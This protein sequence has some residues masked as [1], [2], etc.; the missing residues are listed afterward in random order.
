MSTTTMETFKG[1]DDRDFEVF[2]ISGLESRMDALIERVRPKFH[3]LGE[4]ISQFLGG[5]C[6]EE[7]FTHVAKHA[8]RTVN[9]PNDSWVAFA[10]NKRGYKAHPH[11]QIGLWSTHVFVQFAIIYECPNKN[12]FAE[13]ALGELDSI[14]SAVPDHYVWSKD[15][16][17]P[18]GLTHSDLSEEDL[19]DLLTRLKTVKASELTCGIHIQRGDPLLADGEAF[20]QLVEST[21]RTLLPLYRLAFA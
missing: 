17:V 9:A 6:Q 21:F 4:S 16:M 18:T 15:H 2:E 3:F 1:F 5:L 8:R 14:R 11:F 10:N 13:R 12:I 19:A 7:M 20:I